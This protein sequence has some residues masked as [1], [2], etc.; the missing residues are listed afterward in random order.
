MRLSLKRWVQLLFVCILLFLTAFTLINTAYSAGF[1]KSQVLRSYSDTMRLYLQMIDSTFHNVELNVANLLSTQTSALYA[2]EQPGDDTQA[3]LARQ[4]VYRALSQSVLLS[5]SMDGAFFFSP[6]SDRLLACAYRTLPLDE[7]DALHDTLRGDLCGTLSGDLL[8]WY[9]RRVG[10]SCYLF[11]V[12][13]FSDSYLG[14][15]VSADAL[16]Q[17]LRN[18][19]FLAVDDVCLLGD[20]G[21]VLS[22]ELVSHTL[23]DP[24]YL[25]G[26]EFT[27]DGA[28]YTLVRAPLARAD[29]TLAALVRTQ[30]LVGGL[31]RNL[32]LL[33]ALS[34]L[35]CLFVL[36]A[37]LATKRHML[38][39]LARLAEAMRAFQRGDLEARVDGRTH[40]QELDLVNDTF[41]HMA[42]E[43]TQL[44]IA[45]YESELRRSRTT[46]HFYQ[47]QIRPH[48]LINALNTLFTLAQV[49]NYALIQELTTFLVR[50]YRY[51]LRST[52]TFVRLHD[53]L[54]HV[55]NYLSIQQMRFPDK[56]DVCVDVQENLRGAA[57]P[58]LILQ[59]FVENSIQYAASMDEAV[60]LGIEVRT[61]PARQDE[62]LLTI[63]DTGPGFPD[64]LLAAARAQRPLGDGTDAHIGIYNAQQRLLLAYKGRA[65]LRLSNT[66]PHGARVDIVLPYIPYPPQEEEGLPC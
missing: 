60:V 3:L 35:M 48:F 36:C 31:S 55:E 10:D 20:S 57:V 42:R 5:T 37:Y 28:R 45:N 39:P 41:N 49:K 33:I 2:A 19:S 44:K 63:S 15:Y 62:I 16:L 24:V 64:E 25:P 23:S 4:T 59:S 12:R 7:T 40:V 8:S 47:L 54:E 27:L 14:V 18:S 17:S 56:L 52:G 50:Y 29:L 6:D 58:P 53:E 9:C 26:D 13:P 22:S 1:V 21:A 65:S 61:D 30:R 38:R 34:A 46:L 66:Q 32:Y 43:V 11:F 51:T